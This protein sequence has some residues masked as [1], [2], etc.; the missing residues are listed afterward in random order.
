M[1][2]PKFE[3]GDRVILL[4]KTK[5]VTASSSNIF[6]AGVGYITVVEEDWYVVNTIMGRSGDYFDESDI[7]LDTAKNMIL[8]ILK[9]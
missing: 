7:K 1:K 4:K 8:R 3:V 9:L 2:N 5:G 6:K